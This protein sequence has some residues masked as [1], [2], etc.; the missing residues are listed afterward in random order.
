MRS[1]KV[2]SIILAS[3]LFVFFGVL[4]W[5]LAEKYEEEQK[6]NLTLKGMEISDLQLAERYFKEGQYAYALDIVKK[7]QESISLKSEIGREWLILLTRISEKT[8]DVPQLVLIHE[9]FPNS[10]DYHENASLLVAESLIMEGQNDAYAALRDGWIGREVSKNKWALLDADHLLLQGEYQKGSK[11]LETKLKGKDEISRLIRLSLLHVMENPEKA[12]GYLEEARLNDPSDVDVFLYETK[13]LEKLGNYEKANEIYEIALKNNSQSVFM[14]DQ[15][16][17]FLVRQGDV[18]EAIK[19]WKKALNIPSAK[20]DMLQADSWLALNFFDKVVNGKKHTAS[21]YAFINT[22]KKPLINYFSS[23][24]QDLFVDE[25]T[26]LNLSMKEKYFEEE[27]TVYWFSLLDA[28]SKNEKEKALNLIL[29]TPFKQVSFNPNLEF[30]LLQALNIQLTGEKLNIKLVN[31]PKITHPFLE[32]VVKNEFLEE[33]EEALLRSE[34]AFAALSLAAGFTDAALRLHHLEI[35]PSNFPEWFTYEMTKTMREKLGDEAALKFAL[36]QTVQNTQFFHLIQEM[37][38][39]VA[40]N[41]GNIELAEKIY[42]SL[43]ES[44]MEAKSYFA[45]KAFK[46][47]NFLIAEK[48]TEEL[49]A[50]YPNNTRLLDNL[51]KI[52]DKKG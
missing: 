26:F 41:I 39:R 31:S 52:R 16:A 44:S 13:L 37:N 12:L 11:L 18:Q 8:F 20:E 6:E 43:S 5:P 23:L 28:L 21:P 42:E 15:F 46:D 38:A 48:L 47:R 19:M 25:K 1:L 49:L 30:A 9:Y 22:S 4:Y 45:R 17:H 51:K 3:V 40:L 24:N 7:H 50:A 2:Y 14:H 35:I 34:E 27:Q 32:S 29:N 33:E 36:K 10:L